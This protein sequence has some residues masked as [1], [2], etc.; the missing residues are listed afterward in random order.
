[1]KLYLFDEASV[2]PLSLGN[3]TVRKPPHN[4]CHCCVGNASVLLHRDEVDGIL[5]F[6]ILSCSTLLL[7]YNLEYSKLS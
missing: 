7:V 4:V 6:V 3:L 5:S 2:I 1:M